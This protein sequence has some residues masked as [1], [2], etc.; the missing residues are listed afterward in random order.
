MRET[1]PAL[2]Y[3]DRLLLAFAECSAIF[4]R[5]GDTIDHAEILAVARRHTTSDLSVLPNGA[6]D[7]RHPSLSRMVLH[8]Y[9]ELVSD[10]SAMILA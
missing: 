7:P 2:D 6:A 8:D 5:D 1:T 10:L 3:Q 4:E 9:R